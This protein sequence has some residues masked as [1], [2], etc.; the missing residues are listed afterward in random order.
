MKYQ[1]G[2]QIK[3]ARNLMGM[4]GEEL[5]ERCDISTTYL[6]QLEGGKKTPSI[7]TLGTLCR[8]LNVS[9]S[10]LLPEMESNDRTLEQEELLLAVRGMTPEQIHA[11]ASAIRTFRRELGW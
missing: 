9:P 1:T 2:K 11:V 10:Y 7:Q 3:K 8:E 6:R 4:T 5:A